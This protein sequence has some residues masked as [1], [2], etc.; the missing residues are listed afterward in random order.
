MIDIDTLIAYETGQLAEEDTIAFF[1]TLVD[2]GLV[3]RLQGSYG[4]TAAVLIEEG[5]VTL[6]ACQRP[7]ESPSEAPQAPR[8]Y[9]GPYTREDHRYGGQAAL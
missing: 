6:P 1:Q 5:L 8:S 4:R 2:T 9:S 7:A 3:W